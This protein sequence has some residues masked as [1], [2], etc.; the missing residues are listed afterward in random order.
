[1]AYVSPRRARELYAGSTFTDDEPG[2][3]HRFE[4]TA[5]LSTPYARG[6]L[7]RAAAALAGDRTAVRLGG[8]RPPGHPCADTLIYELT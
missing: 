7:A 4:A 2:E 1:M 3:G 5:A 8:D 6:A